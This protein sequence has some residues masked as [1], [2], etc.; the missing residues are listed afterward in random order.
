MPRFSALS[1]GL[2]LRTKVFFLF[3]GAALLIVVPTLAL[4]AR[5]VEERVYERAIEELARSDSS[6]AGAWRVRGENLLY[7][8]SARAVARGLDD[9]WAEGD[10]RAIERILQRRVDREEGRIVLAADST[11]TIL[12]GPQ[13]DPQALEALRSAG[14]GTIVTLPTGG[15]APIRLAVYPALTDSGVVGL[16]GVGTPLGA[17]ALRDLKTDVTPGAD[18]ALLV[19]DSLIASTL[20]DS[21]HR[22]LQALDLPGGMR[23]GTI[24]RRKLGGESY[25]YLVVSLPTR[26]SRAT[27][28]LLRPVGN[29]L[30]VVTGIVRSLLGVGIVALLLALGLALVVARIV[31]RPAQALA[32]ASARLARGD[33]RAPLPSPSGDE[34]GVL[35]R[36]FADMRSAIAEREARLRSAQAEMIH[37]EKLA[38]MGRLVAQLS[39]EINNPIYN[40]QNCLEALERRGDPNDPN[41]E[42]L[43]L[44]QEELARMASLTRR[45]LDHSRPLSDAAGPMDLNAAVQR[46]LALAG[47]EL[48]GRGVKVETWLERGMPL[49]VAHP[50]GIQQ[51]LANLVTNAM[52]AMPG[53][54]TLRIATRAAADAVE[55]SVE[56]TGSG[57]A[58]DQLPHIFEAFYTTKPG[59][60]GLGLGL[61][62]SEG[63]IRGHRGR[64]SVESRPGR[65]SRFT[66][67]LPRETLDET[68]ASP[69]REEA[70]AHAAV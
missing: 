10:V 48:A 60:R 53:G 21:L 15:G 12:V 7:D 8:A 29:E 30:R 18:L 55:V 5:A 20:P 70:G 62:V 59:V 64:I 67:L 28:L 39:H 50:D 35:T 43:L 65:G 45:M 3:A 42:F 14:S 27:V 34:I 26:G 23:A 4:I 66:V 54:G 46:V 41:R 13:V 61:F 6:L 17:A 36:T 19:G 52:D 25:Q 38:A 16:V 44:A 51:V 68:L 33:F 24:A 57:I 22:E 58:E 31:A 1:R 63:I 11:G 37:R 47:P 32:E 69:D 2:S 9:A 56:D 49:V 40:I